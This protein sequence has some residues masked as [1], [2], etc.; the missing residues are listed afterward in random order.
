[1]GVRL[2][3]GLKRHSWQAVTVLSSVEVLESNPLLQFALALRGKSV[4]PGPPPPT[5]NTGEQGAIR[6]LN[7]SHFPGT[8]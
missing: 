6:M 7:E 4:F 5:F 1:M 3:E 8:L 2:G